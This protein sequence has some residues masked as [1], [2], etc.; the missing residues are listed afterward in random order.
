MTC[1]P[2][3]LHLFVCGLDEIP[4]FGFVRDNVSVFIVD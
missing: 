1:L 2:T 3:C 4:A